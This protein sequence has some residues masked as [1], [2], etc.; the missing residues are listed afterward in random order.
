VSGARTQARASTARPQAA[1]R[2]PEA[3]RRIDGHKEAAGVPVMVRRIPVHRKQVEAGIMSRRPDRNAWPFRHRAPILAPMGLRRDG[4]WAAA[5]VFGLTVVQLALATTMPNLEQFAGKGFTARLVAYPAMMLAAP[6]GWW[7]LARRG[8]ASGATRPVDHARRVPWVPFTWIMLPF[9]ID[10]TGN[11]LDLYDSIWWWDDANHFVNWF[12]LNLG[13]GLLLARAA[14]QPGW[15]L[16]VTVGGVGAIMAIGWE[17]G[18]YFAFI[19]GGTE[20]AT[21]YTDTLGDLTLGTLGALTAGI[22]VA[23]DAGSPRTQR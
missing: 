3:A 5:A 17:L 2:K 8:R 13:V 12:F 19:R 18:E 16:L 15:A 4:R 1:H 14:P 7:L 21:A 10:V 20:L 22:L 6:A 23:R 11:T 9:L